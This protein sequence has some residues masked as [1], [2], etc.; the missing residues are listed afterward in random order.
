MNNKNQTFLVLCFPFCFAAEQKKTVWTAPCSKRGLDPGEGQPLNTPATAGLSP[1]HSDSLE[2]SLIITA[3]APQHTASQA[4]R[5][6]SGWCH[7]CPSAEQSLKCTLIPSSRDATSWCG[8]AT[9]EFLLLELSSLLLSPSLLTSPYSLLLSSIRPLPAHHKHRMKR[10]HWAICQA[11]SGDQLRTAS[12]TDPVPTF[13]SKHGHPPVLFR[14]W[15][16]FWDVIW[17]ATLL[18]KHILPHSSFNHSA[19]HVRNFPPW[20]RI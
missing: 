9:E 13:W 6:G 8:Q 19:P 3:A 1:N 17:D 18:N 7:L 16:D 5:E 12:W 15:D 11:P 4:E 10:P 14:Q 20:K 2:L